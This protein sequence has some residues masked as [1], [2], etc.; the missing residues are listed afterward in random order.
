[1]TPGRRVHLGEQIVEERRH[2][3]EMTCLPPAVVDPGIGQCLTW[4]WRREGP[5]RTEA[6]QRITVASA[7]DVDKLTSL[8][9]IGHEYGD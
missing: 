8:G 3:L 9:P 4:L 2:V 7:F 1:M 5:I 6:P